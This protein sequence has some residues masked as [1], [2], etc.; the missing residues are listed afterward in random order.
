LKA[1]WTTSHHTGNLVPIFAS[2]PGSEAFD[3]VVDNTFIGQ[4]LIQYV[5]A[6]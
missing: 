3:A 1:H 4:T 6:R 2:G 5:T